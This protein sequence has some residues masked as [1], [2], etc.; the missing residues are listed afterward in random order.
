MT[1]HQAVPL[2]GS[3]SV[4]RALSLVWEARGD[5][6]EELLDV[7][8][9]WHVGWIGGFVYIV[10][11]RRWLWRK[12]F[13]DLWSLASTEVMVLPSKSMAGLQL[14][15]MEGGPQAVAEADRR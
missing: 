8:I 5:D 11:N 1:R 14:Q 9:G 15:R 4:L 3:L 13:V 7:G 2:Q 10:E 6:C 12:E